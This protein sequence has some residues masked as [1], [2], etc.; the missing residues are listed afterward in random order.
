MTGRL[1][2]LALLATC[3]LGTACA[4]GAGASG[5]GGAAPESADEVFDLA[6]GS[7]DRV[8]GDSTCA[9]GSH[10]IAFSPGRREM[11][12]TY[13]P[14]SDT[15]APSVFRYRILGWGPEILPPARY[16]IRGAIDGE[17]RLTP[18]G[19]TVIWDLI[20]ATP[21]SYYWHRTD[22]PVDA[23]AAPAVRCDGDR[24]MG[25]WDPPSPE[26]RQGS[27]ALSRADGAS[28]SSASDRGAAVPLGSYPSAAG[29]VPPRARR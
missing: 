21:H 17:T 18:S 20:M 28:E 24:P 26:P 25:P 13:P 29:L 7:W 9:A 27:Q 23:V 14:S 22:W 2:C 8:R 10:T 12:L 6:V 15:V 1:H 16:V 3:W 4:G 5:S 19:E 11:V